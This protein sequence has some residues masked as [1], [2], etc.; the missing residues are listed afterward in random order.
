MLKLQSCEQIELKDEEE[1]WK[2]EIGGQSCVQIL[3]CF[4]GGWRLEKEL[5]RILLR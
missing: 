4:G 1:K 5:V 3:L 2:E